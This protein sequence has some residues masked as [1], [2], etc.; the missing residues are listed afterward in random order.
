MASNGYLGNAVI[1]QI[2]NSVDGASTTW[3]TIA[4]VRDAPSRSGG[5]TTVIDAT[6]HGET[7]KRKSPGL[8]DEGQLT[9]ACLYDPTSTSYTTMRT[10]Y[11]G[12]TK[13][14]IKITDPNTAGSTEEFVGFISNIGRAYPLDDLMTIDVTFEIDGAATF[15]SEPS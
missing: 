2:G 8:R 10:L 1:I 6:V 13:R 14:D 7:V 5:G 15:T 11:E 12:R 3:T 4:Y 9:I